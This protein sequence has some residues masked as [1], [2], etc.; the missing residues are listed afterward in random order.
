M[1]IL[2]KAARRRLALRRQRGMTLIETAVT[3][4]IIVVASVYFAQ[5]LANDAEAIKAKGVA[6]KLLEVHEASRDYL[7]QH[8][9][10]LLN[11]LSTTSTRI[12]VEAGRPSRGAAVPGSPSNCS[13]VPSL[14]GGGFLGPSY[15]DRNG[16]NQQHALLVRKVNVNGSDKIDAMV[17]TYGGMRIPDRVLA[18]VAGI[19]GAA[20]GYLPEKPLSGDEGYI[21]GAYGGWRASTADWS[22]AT[23]PPTVGHL[24][25]TM[26]FGDGSVLADFL[27]RNDIGIP[28]A[29]RMNTAIDMNGNDINRVRDLNAQ[30]H[31]ETAEGNITAKQGNIVAEQGD[32]SG[33]NV[34]ATETVGG[35]N[36]T[37]TEDVAAGRDVRA[38][39]DVTAQRNVVARNEVQTPV[40][41]DLDDRNF[42]VDPNRVSRLNDVNPNYINADAVIYDG[43]KWTKEHGVRLKDLLPR[44]AAQYSYLVTN[45]SIVEKP[46]CLPG[47]TPKIML[48][49]QTD[50]TT[51]SF[52]LE[53]EALP[54]REIFQVEVIDSLYATDLGSSWSVNWGGMNA[55]SV[56]RRAIAQTFCF[57]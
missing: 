56:P 6:E 25:A 15:I 52:G 48:Y 23:R 21:V 42:Y 14:Q 1:R 9:V 31:I 49:R 19:V 45:G 44:Q 38:A 32:V 12:V 8:H 30:R 41:Y 28:E 33:I 17:V 20:G 18:R 16:Y 37:A 55:G 24:A 57:Y 29:N 53:I 51:A 50:S 7:K 22:G 43:T 5:M 35:K 36:V 47:G 27:Y 34:W 2:D 3:L 4:T 11:C 54:Y 10:A 46:K 13:A 39:Q 40:L 26:A